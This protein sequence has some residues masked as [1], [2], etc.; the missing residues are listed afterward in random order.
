MC[1]ICGIVAVSPKVE[2]SPRVEQLWAMMGALRHRGPDG[3]GYFV[4]DHA[5]LGH[6]RL[7][8][9]DTANGEQPMCNEDARIWVSYNGEIFNHVELR[10]QLRDRGHEFRTQCD[11]EVIVHAWEEW[12]PDSFNRFNGQW[13]IALWIGRPRT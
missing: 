10:A 13:A 6:T 9:V 11:T 12:G 7:A 8:I 4:D 5:A 3:S 2:S 1:G